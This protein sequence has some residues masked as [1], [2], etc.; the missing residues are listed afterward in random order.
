MKNKT[1]I[2][3]VCLLVLIMVSAL[4]GCTEKERTP[5]VPD[6]PGKV[7]EL[8]QANFV[9]ELTYYCHSG[10][11]FILKEDIDLSTIDE[12]SPIG[13]TVSTAFNG[14]IDG[15]G[16][17]ITGMKTSGWDDEGQPITV[18]KRIL[19]WDENGEIVYKGSKIIDMKTQMNGEYKEVT[20]IVFEG[21]NGDPKYSSMEDKGIVE[22]KASY[23]SLG[24]FG[25]TSGAK[26]SNLTI[27]DAHFNF[28]GDGDKVYVGI[29]S[30]YDIGS[31]F[32]DVTVTDCSIGA[33]VINK[34]KVTYHYSNAKPSRVDYD[35]QQQQYLGGVVGYSIGNMGS[36][37]E[38]K[39]TSFN[40]VKVSSLTIENNKK[41]A[42]YDMKLACDSI[43]R[44]TQQSKVDTSI[45]YTELGDQETPVYFVDYQ[46][47]MVRQAFVG[48]I[49]GYS[50]D[51]VF[52]N[53]TA[54][55][56]FNSSLNAYLAPKITAQKINIGGI[57]SSLLGAQSKAENVS[58]KNMFIAGNNVY[59]TA[60][61]GGLFGEIKSCKVDASAVADS[62]LLVAGSGTTEAVCIG[63]AVG[64]CDESAEVS[65]TAVDNLLIQSNYIASGNLG[66][67]LAGIVGVLR[68]SHLNNSTAKNITF[69][70]DVY[71][72]KDENYLF[73]R[74]AVSQ[75]YGN[76]VISE[77]VKTYA[78][79][80]FSAGSDDAVDYSQ[81][82]PVVAKNNYVNEN[83][84]SS[85][86]LYYTVNGETAGVYVTVYAELIPLSFESNYRLYKD[87]VYEVITRDDMD[88]DEFNN[89]STS[90]KYYFFEPVNQVWRRITTTAEESI[91]AYNPDRKYAT[92]RE[93][94][95]V[96]LPEEAIGKPMA[97]NTFEILVFDKGA[98]KLET[99]SG[100]FESGVDYYIDAGSNITDYE[101]DVTVYTESDKI[102]EAVKPNASNIETMTYRFTAD[103]YSDDVALYDNDGNVLYTKPLAEVYLGIYFEEGT[104]FKT[105]FNGYVVESNSG[106][107]NYAS[108][109]LVNGRPDIKE[110]AISYSSTIE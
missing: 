63:G 8:T 97:D 3:I 100:L 98:G 1:R 13:K 79:K 74:N 86:R 15:N 77:N 56:G 28:Y 11:S 50:K 78:C 89:I 22:K 101:L 90:G 6:E 66:S 27:S 102:I 85:A 46:P 94:Y 26:I 24:L 29:V 61:I 16:K 53:S 36:N 30:G 82:T 55:D 109:T 9:E 34:T 106:N 96:D 110:G 25:Y 2:L 19:G 99:A 58:V 47:R 81:I 44:S 72:K 40:G 43:D 92:A 95:R 18:L 21:D 41:S 62:T 73:T 54:V 91:I 57:S 51:S 69:N 83:G 107:R 37:G 87:Q 65:G 31:D 64:I 59:Y 68:D 4:F 7:I 14:T 10:A 20:E 12:W 104:G 84:E 32:T 33:G 49:T 108:Y 105:D 23:G 17:T 35:N 52:L 5:D 42:Y 70:I 103:N 45:L 67:I 88:I 39:K 71:N 93:I 76:S 75:V 38:C 60:T 80:Y 48:G